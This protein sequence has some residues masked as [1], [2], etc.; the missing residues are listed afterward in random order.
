MR[1]SAEN[2]KALLRDGV[3]VTLR[4][5]NFRYSEL[6]EFARLAASS[7][8]TIILAV[9]DNLTFSEVKTLA[10]IAH[11]HLHTDFSRD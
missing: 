11:G 6:M 4:T 2:I 3:P 5:D 7:E 8:T 1:K 9:G 10:D